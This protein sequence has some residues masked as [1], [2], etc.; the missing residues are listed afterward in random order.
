MEKFA[1]EIEKLVQ[2]K[3]S[4]YRKLYDLLIEEKSF[5]VDMKID[6]LWDTVSK[7]KSYI[8]RIELIRSKI[9]ERLEKQYPGLQIKK[10][11]MGVSGIIKYAKASSPEKSLELE[12]TVLDINTLKDDISRQA[13]ENSQFIN[14]NLSVV[15]EILS[16][17]LNTE[18]EEEYDGSGSILKQDANKRLFS[19]QV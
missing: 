1:G 16:T 5:V 4:L 19:A 15:Q 11:T 18:N 13:K 3:L 2:E 10:E 7:K 14:E 8:Y 12:R 9:I 6:S 17:I